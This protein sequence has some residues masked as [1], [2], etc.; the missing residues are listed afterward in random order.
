MSTDLAGGWYV[1]G[2]HTVRAI[3]YLG[4]DLVDKGYL[5]QDFEMPLLLENWGEAL[6]ATIE[7]DDRSP[8]DE[9]HVGE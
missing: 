5:P 3:G 6:V 1:S 7:D 4:V 8:I 9:R 2:A